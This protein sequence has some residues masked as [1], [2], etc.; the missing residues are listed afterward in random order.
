MLLVETK[1][2][3]MDT[4]DSV[5]Q[6]MRIFVCKAVR[7]KIATATLPENF[8]VCCG[9]SSIEG[10]GAN[11]TELCGFASQRSQ[12]CKAAW[13]FGGKVI[14]RKPDLSVGPNW[15]NRFLGLLPR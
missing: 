2:W 13:G 12:T 7:L 4:I 9:N 8:D 10:T 5:V 1:K 15:T 14:A 6:I 3:L 11:E